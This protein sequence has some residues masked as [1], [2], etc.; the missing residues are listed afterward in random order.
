MNSSIQVPSWFKVVAVIAI[1]WNLLGIMAYL[2]QAFMTPEM[3]A[4]LPQE[5]QDA[6]ANRPSWVTAVFALAVFGGFLGSL[7]LLLKKNA[8]KIVLLIS[9]LSII[10]NDIY[11]FIII[12]SISMFGM[13]ALYMQ[14]FV[15][16]FAVYLLILF[17]QAKS[18]GWIN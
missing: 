9:L 1:I 10:A 5:Q 16:V 13:S 8:A 4:A 15:L 12:D 14:I 18:K 7:L 17:N 2:G 3:M 11:N 6:F